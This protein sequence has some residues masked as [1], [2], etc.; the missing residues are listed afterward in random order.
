MSITDLPHV[1]ASLNALSAILIAGGYVLIRK[2]KW[3]AHVAAMI[4]ATATSVAFL[5][6]YLIYHANAGAKRFPDLGWIRTAYLLLLASH[7]IL[8]AT[9]PPLV[10]ASL[11][12]AIRRQWTKHRAISQWTFWIWM[13]VSVTGVMI[14]LALY[15]V[16]KA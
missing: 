16:W 2:G 13:Y 8:A 4:G 11:Y 15:H 10:V 14:Y 9:V 6:C 1:N 3:Q 5:V 7:T 12:R